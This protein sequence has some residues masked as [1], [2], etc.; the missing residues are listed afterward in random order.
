MDYKHL[1]ILAIDDNPDTVAVLKGLV[2]GLLPGVRLL[3]APDVAA[4]LELARAEDPD[5]ILLDTVKPGLDGVSVCRKLKQDDR[6]CAIPVIF[7]T[8]LKPSRESRIEALEAGAEGFLAKPLDEVELTAQ[9]RSMAKIKA[10]NHLQRRETEQLAALVAERTRELA[11]ELAER[12]RA[13]A[14]IENSEAEYRRLFENSV[15]GI[16]EATADG[17]LLRANMAYAKMYGYDSPSQLIAEVSD[18]GKQLYANADDRKEV[19]R[20]LEEK[21]VLLQREVQVVRRDGTP[22]FVLASARAIR[23][24]SGK[25]TCYHGTQVDITERKQA[26]VERERLMAAIKQSGEII[27]ITAPDGTI[28][29]VNP[30]FERITGYDCGEAIGHTPRL[31]KSGQQD[32]AF[33]KEL[34]LTISS[35]RTWQGRMVNRR[36]DSSF[37]TE[38]ATISPV[39]DAAGTVVNYVAIKRDITEHLLLEA[40]FRQAQKM[41]SVGRL[42]GGVAHDFNNLL[43]GIIGYA[44]LCRDCID[45]NH[46]IRVWLDEITGA[47]QRSAAITRQL[48]A[49]A[50]KQTIAPKVIDLDDAVTNMLKLLRRLI[51][52]DID[53]VWMPGVGS[54]MVKMDP[55]QIDQILANLAVNARD[56]IGGVGKLL[57]ETAA[58]TVDDDYCIDHRYAVP[59]SY[60]RL[61]VSDSGCGMDQATLEHVFEPFFT[62]KGTGQGTGLG[63]ATVYGIVKQNNGF[64]NVYS[65]PGKGTTFKIYLPRY[66]N[67][68]TDLVA[69]VVPP[70][71]PRG[72]ETILL[73]E[74]EPS[75][76]V[77]GQAFLERQGYT[78]LTAETPD[79]ALRLFSEYPFRVHLLIT[80]LVMPGLSGRDLANQLVGK[81]PEMRVIFMSGYTADVIAHRGILDKDVD[82]MAKPFS[83]AEL[84]IKVREVLD[85]K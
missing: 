6:L 46:A 79:Q 48:L 41:E 33:Y 51:G 55:S 84:L 47:A 17:R 21:D 5:V 24:P 40:Q 3:I 26:E 69:P 18:I 42:A 29:F 38:E 82:F 54:A 43:M 28:Q 30:A 31:L 70:A 71:S 58:A 45:R 22:C 52:E 20:I 2:Q 62:T 10:A 34:W 63:L 66:A 61:A 50:R 74:D 76:L 4:G 16:S 83:R 72:T 49:F 36:K 12:K 77:T 32:E 57:I 23:D 80:D 67:E 37:Y 81:S 7:L 68:A 78:V 1:K 73:V 39:C 59:G 25:L 19:L 9:I 27:V 75:I 53:L 14:A 13:E 56:A 64:I 11:Q 8:G 65:E 44:E 35:G 60:V 85:R 15:M